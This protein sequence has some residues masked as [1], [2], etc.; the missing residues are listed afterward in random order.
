[1]KPFGPDEL[2]S[3][4]RPMIDDHWPNARN[5]DII[6]LEPLGRDGGY[7]C[8]KWLFLENDRKGRQ[9]RA[10]QTYEILQLDL[11]FDHDKY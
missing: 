3:C 2:R 8:V 7:F 1:V 10:H 11:K 5:V 4:G 6:I 9:V